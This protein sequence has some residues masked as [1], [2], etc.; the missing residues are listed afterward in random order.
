MV[1]QEKNF[2]NINS[3]Y[4]VN[5]PWNGFGESQDATKQY[6]NENT[7]VP[8]INYPSGVSPT[9]A[10]N[11]TKMYKLNA[12]VNKTGLEFLIKVM[13]GDKIDIH[14][15]SYHNNTTTVGSDNSTQL[16][17]LG[18]LTNLLG[19]PGNPI[20]GKGITATQLE[21]SASGIPSTFFTWNN[22]E[23][24]TIPKAFINYILLDEQ[25]K[26]VSGG[27]SRVGSNGSVKNHFS[28]DAATLQNINVTKNGYLLVYVSNESNFDVFFDNLQVVHRPGPLTEETHYY[29]FGLTMSGISSKSATVLENK[30]KFGGKESQSGEF[31][32]GTGLEAYDFGARNYDPQIG[33]WHTIDPLAE[34][35]RRWSTYT[36]AFNN[37][38]RFIDPDGMWAYE[39]DAFKIMKQQG[40]EK[41]KKKETEGSTGIHVKGEQAQ[42]L[43]GK[44]KS[45]EVSGSE[46]ISSINEEDPI[47]SG[48]VEVEEITT[49]YSYHG[50]HIAANLSKFN[51]DF[52]YKYTERITTKEQTFSYK[53][54]NG[55]KQTINAYK[56]TTDFE[57]GGWSVVD[58]SVNA[59]LTGV[60][61]GWSLE[62]QNVQVSA[63]ATFVISMNARV[64]WVYDVFNKWDKYD[65]WT[66]T[67]NLH[68][69]TNLASIND[70]VRY[71]SGSWR[72][73]FYEGKWKETS[74]Q[75][76]S[77]SIRKTVPKWWD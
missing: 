74:R 11:S 35:G 24:G 30:F 38:L 37:P 49:S 42:Q 57:G 62:I 10:T 58:G 21:T 46:L 29:P 26:F 31:A 13:S 34:K 43:I 56:S 36:Y 53:L 61:I 41:A 12:T 55:K 59:Y 4:I 8:N 63:A 32:D 47:K 15:K 66:F 16:T 73:Q 18:M 54:A 20:S 71:S 76:G 68:N 7:P 48:E 3:S 5:E 60:S 45:G 19:A 50:E 6:V 23:G 77:N 9:Q 14:G 64:N 65:E 28:V 40:E 22:G 52:D 75:S 25:F 1:N 69:V 44:L 72:S 33:R 51:L 70:D 17:L 67:I 39:T 27:A 2:Y